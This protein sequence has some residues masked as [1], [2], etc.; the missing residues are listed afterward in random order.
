MLSRLGSP[1]C[2]LFGAIFTPLFLTPFERDVKANCETLRAFI[3]SIVEK[4]RAE[5]ASDPSLKAKKGDFLTILLTEPHFK[6]NDS[7]II[8][9]C[10]TFFF[11]G[12]QTSA[13]TTQNLICSLVKHP[14]Y[15]LKLRNELF[16]VIVRPHLDTNKNEQR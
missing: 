7:R 4:R 3:N 6:D 1:H 2:L 14:E 9:E 5:L 12:S 15:Q 10:L 13:A 8:D 11:A 16:D